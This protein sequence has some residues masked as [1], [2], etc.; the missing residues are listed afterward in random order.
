MKINK[1]GREKQKQN[2][3]GKHKMEYKLNN[4]KLKV[5]TE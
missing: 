1:E 2:E 3:N 5:K 4:W